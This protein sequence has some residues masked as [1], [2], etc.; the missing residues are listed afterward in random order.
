MKSDNVFLTMNGQVKLGE[1]GLPSLRL[2]LT[3]VTGNVAMCLLDQ[4]A[5]TEQEDVRGVGR[6]LKEIMEPGDFK[7][8]PDSRVLKHP[9]DWSDHMRGFLAATQTSRLRDLLNVRCLL[10]LWDSADLVACTFSIFGQR[11]MSRTIGF[12]S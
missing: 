9:A 5:G 11:G 3:M 12:H 1:H 7:K 4:R 6:I 2:S 10:P 8:N